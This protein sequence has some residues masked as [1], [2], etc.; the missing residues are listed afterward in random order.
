MLFVQPL[1]NIINATTWTGFHFANLISPLEIT[2]GH[3]RTLPTDL[4]ILRGTRTAAEKRW[5]LESYAK[6]VGFFFKGS[7]CRPLLCP[8]SLK[9]KAAA[10]PTSSI[11]CWLHCNYPLMQD[12]EEF[13]SSTRRISL[14]RFCKVSFLIMIKNGI[15]WLLIYW[16]EGCYIN[17]PYYILPLL[18]S[19][20]TI[21]IEY[22][23]YYTKKW[24]IY[25]TYIVSFNPYQQAYRLGTA[26][27][28]LRICM[29]T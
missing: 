27:R 15:L 12:P 18:L 10:S 6:P 13:I 2:D 11:I 1:S 19:T 20:L 28:N 7:F 25:H 9:H 24:V 29:L 17:S 21:F 16:K 5:H 26:M 3:V 14:Q 4:C 23:L 22:L 8:H